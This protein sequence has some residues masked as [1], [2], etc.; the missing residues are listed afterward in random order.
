[1]SEEKQITFNEKGI[2]ALLHIL[3]GFFTFIPSLIGLFLVNN[4]SENAKNSIKAA[5]N[6]Q[7]TIL[8][9]YLIL[10]ISINV[11]GFLSFLFPIT[12]LFVL[13]YPAISIANIIIS[14]LAGFSYYNSETV[15]YPPHIIFI[16]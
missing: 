6:F 2:I 4:L 13:L 16:K 3:G 12:G 10:T 9:I 14:F 7:L 11:I 15:N 5:L 1:M 8:I